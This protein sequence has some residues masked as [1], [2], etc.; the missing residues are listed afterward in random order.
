MQETDYKKPNPT[1]K[2]S[3]NTLIKN[4]SLPIATNVP[5]IYKD[6]ERRKF[7]RATNCYIYPTNDY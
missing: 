7:P 4:T 5:V 3:A 2:L 1:K 6:L